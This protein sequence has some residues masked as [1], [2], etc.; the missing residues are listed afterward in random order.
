[1]AQIDAVMRFADAGLVWGLGTVLAPAGASARDVR[2][3]EG[4]PRLL[5]LLAAAHL[6]PP[7]P[8]GLAH[9]R[10]AADCRREGEDALAQMHLALSRLAR[11]G[12]PVV[13][14]R[15]LF[16]ADHLLNS[17]F[18]AETIFK[19]LDLP[20]PRGWVSKYDPAEPRVP[21]GS[22]RTSGQWTTG[23]SSA[24]NPPAASS[25]G[26]RP[27]GDPHRAPRPPPNIIP[28]SDVSLAGDAFKPRQDIDIALRGA[29][30]TSPAVIV[31]GGYEARPEGA[32]YDYERWDIPI[33]YDASVGAGALV[34]DAYIEAPP[35]SAVTLRLG[36][37]G[38][39]FAVVTSGDRT[40]AVRLGADVNTGTDLQIGDPQRGGIRVFAPSAQQAMQDYGAAHILDNPLAVPLLISAGTFDWAVSGAFIESLAARGAAEASATAE[41]VTALVFE[42]GNVARITIYAARGRAFED[43]GIEGILRPVGLGKNHALV[44]QTLSNGRTVRTIVDSAGRPVGFVEFKDVKYI[45]RTRQL[46]AQI[47]YAEENG[48]PYNLVVSP[49]T[50]RISRPLLKAIDNFKNTNGGSIFRYDPLN[51]TLTPWR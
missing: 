39:L 1:L 11:L 7:T 5:A 4:Q 47:E 8:L 12:R 6:H 13:D 36:Q 27:A 51:D 44:T 45:T 48:L 33:Q 42:Q 20:P 41:G 29:R 24:A 14:A 37:N 49:N 38:A 32:V 9:L 3:D 23:G 25:A 10:R 19:A 50:E 46:L 40:T 2:I 16:L 31:H 15:R 26:G 28:A 21:A 17:G 30:I 43:A 18:E 35:G 22:G 34:G